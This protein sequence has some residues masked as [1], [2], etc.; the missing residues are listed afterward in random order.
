MKKYSK[1][2]I[3]AV[4]MVAF[5]ASCQCKT[6]KRDGDP[7]VQVCKD[8][9]SEQEYNNSIDNLVAGGYDCN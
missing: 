4:G 2:I 9:G 5:L 8:G 1:L 3:L 6:C 7:S